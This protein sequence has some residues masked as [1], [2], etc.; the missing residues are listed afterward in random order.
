MR[1]H[2]ILRS[3]EGEAGGGAGF[4]EAGVPPGPESAPEAGPEGDAGARDR[5][6]DELLAAERRLADLDRAFRDAARGRAIASALIGKPLVGGAA[7]QLLRLWSDDFD[8]VGEG[9]ESRVVARDGRGVDA[10][11]AERLASPEFAHFCLP[12]SRGGTVHPGESRSTRSAATPATPRTLGEAAVLRWRDA[13]NPN[14]APRT[15]W[16]PPR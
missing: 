12:T 4:D 10:T 11:V 5:L 2:T 15:G 16:G 3:P 13:A 1:T 14:A 9:A 6:A 8:V 7:A